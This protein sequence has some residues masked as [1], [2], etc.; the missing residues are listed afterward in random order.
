[1]QFFLDEK[2]DVHIDE[3][4]REAEEQ[5]ELSDLADS[6]ISCLP[7]SIFERKQAHTIDGVFAVQM[8]SILDISQAAYDQLQT[9]QDKVLDV[10]N[11]NPEFFQPTQPTQKPAKPNL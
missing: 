8:Q 3:L 9:I 2:P 1:M 5:W 4:F 6:G 7:N 11:E 10:G